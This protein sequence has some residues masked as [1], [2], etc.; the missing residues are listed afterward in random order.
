M[1]QRS[2]T[3]PRPVTSPV[4]NL[5]RSTRRDLPRKI[6][7]PWIHTLS[8]VPDDAGQVPKRTMSRKKATLRQRMAG[9][10]RPHLHHCDPTA[11][12]GLPS[13]LIRQAYDGRLERQ[14]VA[15]QHSPAAP[16]F[17]GN[18]SQPQLLSTSNSVW[19]RYSDEDGSPFI[20]HNTFCHLLETVMVRSVHIAKV[21]NFIASS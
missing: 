1:T 8:P 3:L 20:T 9:I 17:S 15:A 16:V 6:M 21:A 7:L 2:L 4:P 10:I 18:Q 19:P 12:A 13:S 11:I 5:T 14:D